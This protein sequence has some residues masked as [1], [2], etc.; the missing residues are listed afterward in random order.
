M[1]ESSKHIFSKV[2]LIDWKI[3]VM[4]KRISRCSKN[5]LVFLKVFKSNIR[6]T[7]TQRIPSCHYLIKINAAKIKK[8]YPAIQ[9][10][11]FFSSSSYFLYHTTNLLTVVEEFWPILCFG[12]AESD[13][14]IRRPTFKTWSKSTKLLS[15][16]IE[17]NGRET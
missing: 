9:Q 6:F 4:T 7:K 3:T 13:P 10:L 16:F 8:L 11:T 12:A 15:L 17:E 5:N 14:V 2:V 1:S